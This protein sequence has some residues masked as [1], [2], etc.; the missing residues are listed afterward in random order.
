VAE[1]H[2]SCIDNLIL[3]SLYEK[4]DCYTLGPLRHLGQFR[5]PPAP[6]ERVSIMFSSHRF[7]TIVMIAL[8]AVF[9]MTLAPP[10][11][12]QLPSPK[13]G[14]A[15]ADQPAAAQYTPSL[16]YQFGSWRYNSATA[17][18]VVRIT[19]QSTGNYYI[20]F[21]TIGS[22]T[23]GI[24]HVNAYG[25]TPNH[26]HPTA[27]SG[28]VLDE[29][30][31]VECRTTSGALV[32]NRFT[33]LFTNAGYVDSNSNGTVYGYVRTEINNATSYQPTN[34]F[35]QTGGRNVIRHPS[36]GYYE[37]DF[38]GP[39][40]GAA[41]GHVQVTSELFNTQCK[42]WEWRPYEAGMRVKVFCF[43]SN[44]QWTDGLFSLSFTGSRPLHNDFRA[45]FYGYLLADWAYAPFNTPYDPPVA[46]SKNAITGNTNK[47]T[48]VNAG[49]YLVQ[50][51]GLGWTPDNVQ[52]TSYGPLASFCQ[53]DGWGS[54]RD[55]TVRV[56]C[57]TPNG[58][59]AD[60]PFT[61]AYSSSRSF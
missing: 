46:Y 59:W 20:R 26:C 40:W 32:D 22:G 47:V 18:A 60:A 28:Y 39:D 58:Q 21:P 33:I 36:P 15:W 4:P 3:N 34:Q 35:N 53:P 6:K 56:L 50:F 14:F 5:M 30:V 2:P 49:Y 24:V 17:G 43:K 8:V 37:V 23:S 10:A 54:A 12:A 11:Q 27:W 61:I 41:R 31:Y 42:V 13:W 7:L 52:V 38:P 48:H 9:S 57:Y 45:P 16:S 25:P 44:G 1:E 55:A 51:T 29:E 19:H